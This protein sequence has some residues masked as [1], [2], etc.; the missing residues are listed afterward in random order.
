MSIAE[1]FNYLQQFINHHTLFNITP[2][3]AVAHFIVGAFIIML[4]LKLKTRFG[5]ALLIL[6]GASLIKECY[7]FYLRPDYSPLESVR[8]I[9]ISFIFPFILMLIRI[10]KKNKKKN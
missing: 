3:D 2:L 7:D 4:L 1:L 9:S 8:D 6:L 5:Q 10:Y